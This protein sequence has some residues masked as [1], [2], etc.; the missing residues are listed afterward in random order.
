VIA[1]F[2]SLQRLSVTNPLFFS[3]LSHMAPGFSV[4][5][6]F[7][8]LRPPNVHDL[9]LCE[10][11]DY[12]MFTLQWFS[13]RGSVVD[14]LS[15]ALESL[16][17]SPLNDYLQVLGPSLLFLQIDIRLGLTGACSSLFSTH[18]ALLAQPYT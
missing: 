11:D 3:R 8:H 5:D 9:V 6:I 13:S 18:Q 14:S 7:P 4:A 16:A 2:P 1:R 15:V 12:P 17:L 10:T